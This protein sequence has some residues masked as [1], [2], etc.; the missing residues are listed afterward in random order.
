MYKAVVAAVVFVSLCPAAEAKNAFKVAGPGMATCEQFAQQAI[1]N[2]QLEAFYFSWGQGWMS[3][4]NMLLTVSGDSSLATDLAA[5]GI[6]DQML[7]IRAYC[8]DNPFKYYEAAVIDLYNSMRTAQGL[9]SW[10]AN[11]KQR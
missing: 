3:A 5:V 1:H 7:Y 11:F 4:T 10:I 8:E 9:E 6:E 2:K